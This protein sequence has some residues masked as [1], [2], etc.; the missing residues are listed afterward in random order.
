MTA[1]VVVGARTTN[2]DTG[3]ID[4]L[5]VEFIFVTGGVDTMSWADGLSGSEDDHLDGLAAVLAADNDAAAF[6]SFDIVFHNAPVCSVFP[7]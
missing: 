1:P 5:A 4:C 6:I 3:E 2:K 7:Q